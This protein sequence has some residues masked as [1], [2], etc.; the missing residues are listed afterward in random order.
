MARRKLFSRFSRNS[1]VKETR[2][3]K[4]N[5]KYISN[6]M[7]TKTLQGMKTV[8]D[9]GLPPSLINAII[10]GDLKAAKKL[11]AMGREGQAVMRHADDIIKDSLNYIEGQ[12]AYSNM[13]LQIYE[14]GMKS[15][16]TIQQNS[17]KLGSA[18]LQHTLD[19]NHNREQ[20][21]YDQQALKQSAKHASELL[22]LNAY[23]LSVNK[24]IDHEYAMNNSVN[25]T[26]RKMRDEQL[27]YNI[28]ALTEML[29]YGDE[30][31]L[32]LIAQKDYSQLASGG[33]QVNG[34]YGFAQTIFTAL[35][36]GIR[37]LLPNI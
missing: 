8:H 12:T 2:A 35:G 29:R 30:G 34:V 31:D 10:K 33:G 9:M 14:G 4:D 24:D 7:T 27:R 1:T 5:L 21:V 17:R 16:T 32:S 3:K 18:N 25:G 36:D 20:W 28:Q 23:L 11:G 15:D 22:R 37:A 13:W 26:R 6:R 19:V